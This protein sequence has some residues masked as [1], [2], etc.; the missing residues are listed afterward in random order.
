MEAYEKQRKV[1]SSEQDHLKRSK[2]MEHYFSFQPPRAKPVPDFQR[3]QKH[4]QQSLESK[5]KG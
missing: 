5:R 3:L 1:L 4:F 2:S